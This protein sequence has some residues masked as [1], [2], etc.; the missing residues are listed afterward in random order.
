MLSKKFILVLSLSLLPISFA[1]ALIPTAPQKREKEKTE[2]NRSG[3]NMEKI[4][5]CELDDRS[6][7]DLRL[8]RLCLSKTNTKIFFK[9][10]HPSF[11]CTILENVTFRDNTGRIYSAVSYEGIPGCQSSKSWRVETFSWSFERMNPNAKTFDL[12]EKEIPDFPGAWSWKEISLKNCRF[13][14][15]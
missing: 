13:E 10:D 15:D 2:R 14:S 5:C 7:G 12:F 9:Y 8:I 6:Q 11:A 4:S 1:L 3:K